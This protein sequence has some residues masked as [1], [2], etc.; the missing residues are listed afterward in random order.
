QA[1]NAVLLANESLR[2]GADDVA[3]RDLLDARGL[4]YSVPLANPPADDAFEDDDDIDHPTPIGP[5]VHTGLVS[6]ADDWFRLAVPG[7]RRWHVTARFDPDA[8]NLD[9]ALFALTGPST[10]NADLLATSNGILGVE[11]VDA[12]AGPGGGTFFVRAYDGGRGTHVTGYELD[13]VD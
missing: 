11:A 5:G 10:V 2:A 9:L 6:V 1:A 12:S 13:V 7:N 4:I 3:I 8:E